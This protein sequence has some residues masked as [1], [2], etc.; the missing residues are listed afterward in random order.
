MIRNTYLAIWTSVVVGSVVELELGLI[1]QMR[2]SPLHEVR[3][4]ENL[5]R[6]DRRAV[7]GPP[8]RQTPKPEIIR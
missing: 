7:S 8:F 1:T 2:R 6:R 3:F 5:L 4:H